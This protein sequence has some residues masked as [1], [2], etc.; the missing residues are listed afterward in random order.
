MAVLRIWAFD[1]GQTVMLALLASSF[2]AAVVLSFVRSAQ[3]VFGREYVLIFLLVLGYVVNPR[4]GC[5]FSRL[6]ADVIFRVPVVAYPLSLPSIKE[7]FG[8]GN[9][10][11]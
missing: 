8:A 2:K 11:F 1:M 10:W 6:Q 4:G 5:C 3:K 9:A 7:L